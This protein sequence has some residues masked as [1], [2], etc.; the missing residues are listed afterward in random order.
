MRAHRSFRCSIL[1]V[2]LIA[3]C[4]E[5]PV[6]TQESALRPGQALFD[7]GS[8]GCTPEMD[9]CDDG[10]QPPPPP[11]VEDYF[12]DMD[13][14]A[15]YSVTLSEAPPDCPAGLQLASTPATLLPPGENPLPIVSSGWAPIDY[16]AMP[17]PYA[18]YFWPPNRQDAEGFWPAV[19]G[20]GRS[21][22][23]GSG[24][25]RCYIT[26]SGNTWTL[27]ASFFNYE[28]V[29]IRYPYRQTSGGSSGGG[30]GNNCHTEWVTLEIDRNDG[31]GW[32]TWWEGYATVCE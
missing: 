30:A 18:R 15:E 32:V 3:G 22:Y 13:V 12:P 5:A 28:R 4:S 2:V 6:P 21:A 8:G 24:V 31:L 23:V 25:A 27:H 16:G 19:D 29:R 11:T 14:S 10:S 26:T 17:A 20:S 1:F 7:E 9:L